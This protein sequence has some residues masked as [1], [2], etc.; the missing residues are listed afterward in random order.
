MEFTKLE[1]QVLLTLKDILQETECVY[2]ADLVQD[3]PK[4]LR[5]ALASLV[6]KNVIYVDNDHP[7]NINGVTY[8]P[9]SWDDDVIEA[10][11][12]AA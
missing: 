11:T 4:Q 1:T 2:S 5:G 6:N 3:N 10:L 8:Y 7:S 12:E 9:V